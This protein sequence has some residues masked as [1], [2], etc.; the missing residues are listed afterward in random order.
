MLCDAAP[1]RTAQEDD[2]SM[3]KTLGFLSTGQLVTNRLLKHYSRKSVPDRNC[4]ATRLAQLALLILHSHTQQV[5][6]RSVEKKDALVLD[7]CHTEG[8]HM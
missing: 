1:S 6:A 2:L 4:S 8:A 5:T 7:A 3:Q